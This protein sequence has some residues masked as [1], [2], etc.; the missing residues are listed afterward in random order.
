MDD[1]TLGFRGEKVS[2]LLTTTTTWLYQDSRAKKILLK[3]D[4]KI[5]ET[6]NQVIQD[7]ESK[8]YVRKVPQRPVV[9]KRQRSNIAYDG[10]STLLVPPTSEYLKQ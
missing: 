4:P 2:Q 1:T 7:Y 10:T 5:A 8:R 3:K 6:Y 9:P